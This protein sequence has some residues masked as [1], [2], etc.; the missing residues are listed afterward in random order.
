MLIIY[1]DPREKVRKK[2]REREKEWRRKFMSALI[3]SA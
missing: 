3:R 2:E 1:V